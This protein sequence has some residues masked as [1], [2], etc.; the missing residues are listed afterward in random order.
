[1]GRGFQVTRKALVF[2]LDGTLVDSIP[3]LHAAIALMLGELG[4]K[5]L[6]IEEV[7]GLVGDGTR[8]LVRRCLVAA[9]FPEDI[10]PEALPR[11]V[12][13]YEKAPVGRTRPYP[14]VKDTLI[15][16]AG[17]GYRLGVCTNKPQRSTEVILKGLGLDPFF[18]AVIGGDKLPIRKPD[19]GHLRAVLDELG[20]VPADAVMIGDHVNDLA[21]ARGAGSAAILARYGYGAEVPEDLRPDREIGCFSEIPDIVAGLLGENLRPVA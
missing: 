6:G 12:A 4:G 21:A 18:G 19:P 10:L 17:R 7:R 9:G 16:L 14:G 20:A 15:V 5:P 8:V 11:F 13:H 3:D 2:D 1:M